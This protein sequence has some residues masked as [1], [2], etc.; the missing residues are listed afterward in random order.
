[1]RALHAAG[2]RTF[3]VI[4]PVLPMD[5]DRLVDMIAP[6]VRAVRQDKLYVGE[7]IM[8]LSEQPGLTGYGTDDYATRTMERLTAAFRARGVRVETLDNLEALLSP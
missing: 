3:A 5:P 6:F 4:Q 7:R 2:V 1:L 8:H